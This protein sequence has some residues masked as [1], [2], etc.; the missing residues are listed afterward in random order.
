MVAFGLVGEAVV[1]SGV[2][3]GE[4]VLEA[5]VAANVG[6]DDIVAVAEDDNDRVVVVVVVGRVEE[7]GDNTK[8]NLGELDR[9]AHCEQAFG[10]S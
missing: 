6:V 10:R 5:V 7:A 3:A 4:A 2:A 1:A 9:R 8:P